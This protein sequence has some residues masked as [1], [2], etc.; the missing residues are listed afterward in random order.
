M[1]GSEG[2]LDQT[3]GLAALLGP[4]PCGWAA[5]PSRACTRDV[6]G[7]ARG[8]ASRAECVRFRVSARARVRHLKRRAQAHACSGGTLGLFTSFD[9][10]AEG[11]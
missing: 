5:R 2:L 8:Q 7:G 10:K 4:S 9:L 6:C 1:D 11:R 3:D